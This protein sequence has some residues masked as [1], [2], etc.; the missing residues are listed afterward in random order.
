MKRFSIWLDRWNDWILPLSLIGPKVANLIFFYIGL[1]LK[2]NQGRECSFIAVSLAIALLCGFSFLN[3][4]K[5]RLLSPSRIALL[6][7]PLL[8]YTASFATWYLQF[9]AA[10]D[11]LTIVAKFIVYCIPLF[12]C[13]ICVAVRRNETAFFEKM[14]QMS[15]LVLPAAIFYTNSC[16]FECNPFNWGYDFGIINYMN[17]AYT[18]MPFL[19]VH[20]LRFADEESLYLPVVKRFAMRP[21]LI[22]G[23]LIALYWYTIIATGTRGAYFCVVGFSI[24]LVFSRCIH[25]Q[26]VKRISITSGMVLGL[27]VFS[28]FVYTLPGLQNT[29]RMTYFIE[30]L[31]SG[32]I[33]TSTSQDE[34][35]DSYVDEFVN[36]VG[37]EQVANRPQNEDPRIDKAPTTSEDPITGEDSI[38]SEN[39][40]PGEEPTSSEEPSDIADK[41]L[42]ISNRGTLF[43][44]A[45]K[46][47]KKAPLTGMGPGGFTVKYGATPHSLPLELLSDTG[48]IG[49]VFMMSLILYAIVRLI[50]IGQKRKETRYMLLFLMAYA[51]QAI[52]SGSM[53][54]NPVLPWALAY[55]LGISL[56]SKNVMPVDTKKDMTV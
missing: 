7:L 21:Q 20:M 26:P 55:G 41:N 29:S 36:T 40:I 3:L 25:H 8:F 38:P 10:G 35:V 34:S 30:G 53:W 15:F 23:A 24:L 4:F 37:G 46:E 2:E 47:F 52:L 12:L 27:L 5:S 32:K 11:L 42:E 50:L 16:I 6:S 45:L 19:L 56:S 1:C 28:L 39:P 17:F 13:G 31:Q 44:L 18:V 54:S 22:R 48:L 51:I 49:T 43:T 9:G 14:E 33:I